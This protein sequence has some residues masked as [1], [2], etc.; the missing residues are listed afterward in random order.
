MSESLIQ[1][2]ENRLSVL[3]SSVAFPGHN[4]VNFLSDMFSGLMVPVQ[5][6]RGSGD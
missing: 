2:F 4:P 3:N 1:P 5:G 6:P